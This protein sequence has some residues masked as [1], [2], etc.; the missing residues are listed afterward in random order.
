MTV[1][2]AIAS[3]L[4]F[5]FSCAGSGRWAPTHPPGLVPGS[6]RPKPTS[7]SDCKGDRK[8]QLGDAA[9]RTHQIMGRTPNV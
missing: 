5:R 1:V 4:A 9:I 8:R 3:Y 7:Y 2:Q 6:H